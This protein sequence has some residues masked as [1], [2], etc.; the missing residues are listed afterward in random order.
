MLSPPA[1]LTTMM[2]ATGSIKVLASSAAALLRGEADLRDDGTVDIDI[3]TAALGGRDRLLTIEADVRDLSRRTIRGKGSLVVARQDRLATLELDRG[4][5]RPGERPRVAVGLQ[6]AN[7]SGV[8]AAGSVRLSRIRYEGPDLQRFRLEKVH[9]LRATTGADGRVT[10]D[11]PS[12]AEGQYQIEFASP[13]SRG[14]PVSAHTV[15]WVHGPAF[16]PAQ[17]RHPDLEIMPDRPTYQVGDTAQLLVHIRQPHARV[18]W[19]DNARDGQLRNHRFLDV[20]DHVAVIPVRIEVRHVPNFFVEATVVS[21]GQTHVEA[22]EI[23][24]PPVQNLLDVRITT[25]KP[26]YRPG[27]EGSIKVTVTDSAGKP[28]SGPITLTA[29]D[30]AVTYIQEET[31]IGPKALLMKRISQHSTDS[32]EEREGLDVQGQRNFVCP[33]FEIYDNR[34]QIMGLGGGAPQGGDPADVAASRSRPNRQLGDRPRPAEKK[35]PVV[36][37]NFADTAVWRAALELGRDGTATTNVS[38]PESLTTWRLRVCDHQGHAGRRCQR[39]NHDHEKPP[40]STAN[41]TLSCRGGQGGAVRE[42][43]QRTADGSAGSR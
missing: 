40:C 27:E 16:K 39:G 13:D 2:K 30:K 6:T 11:L 5:Y 17:F 37:R 20:N 3:N 10:V 38:W 28:V 25:A 14:E 1:T 29:Y 8:T 24:V 22:C 19:S 9:E 18:L 21:G 26:S 32:Y 23:L 43:P 36:R 35:D 33:E 42:C 7:G 41:A 12:L 15:F 31:G 4:W 34:H